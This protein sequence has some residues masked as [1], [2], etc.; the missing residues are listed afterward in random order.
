M[1]R[2]VRMYRA[3]S[4]PHLVAGCERTSFFAVVGVCIAFGF[5]GGIATGRWWNVVV[6]VLL[7]TAGKIGLGRAAELDPQLREVAVRSHRHGPVLL[8]TVSAREKR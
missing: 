1:R 7:F 4:A 6:A 2:R 8:A 5:F 3:L